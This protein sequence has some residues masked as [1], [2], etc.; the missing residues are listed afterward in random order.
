MHRLLESGREDGMGRS[1]HDM[2]VAQQMDV[3]MKYFWKRLDRAIARNAREQRAHVGNGLLV[4]VA[5][6]A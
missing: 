3:R 2:Y 1:T 5:A 6:A 4:V